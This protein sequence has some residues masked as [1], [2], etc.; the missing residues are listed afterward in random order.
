MKRGRFIRKPLI[1]GRGV[2][3]ALVP[4]RRIALGP[5]GIQ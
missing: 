5:V 3:R 2:L 1:N 4:M